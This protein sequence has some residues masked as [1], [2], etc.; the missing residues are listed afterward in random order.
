MGWRSEIGCIRTEIKK[1]FAIYEILARAT[2]ERAAH[3]A[4]TDQMDQDEG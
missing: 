3:L 1:K 4:T 2:Q